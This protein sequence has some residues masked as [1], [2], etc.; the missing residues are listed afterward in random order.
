ME[1]NCEH[2]I[3]IHQE[4]EACT[5]EFHKVGQTWETKQIR[6]ELAQ[7]D[8]RFLMMQRER[9]A[10]RKARIAYQDA[11]DDIAKGNTG[12]LDA[13]TYAYAVLNPE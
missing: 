6:R 13:A 2:G 1:M 8:A 10:E 9:G 11:L 12:G 3:N 7:V 5:F 4:C